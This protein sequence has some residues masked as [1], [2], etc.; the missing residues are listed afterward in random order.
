[1]AAK[2]VA[3]K[4]REELPAGF[5]PARMRL[6]GFFERE[7]GNS[8]QGILRGA[9]KVNGKFGVKNVF[10]I[11]VTHGETQVGEGEMV[12]PGGVVGLDQ[13]GYTS[14]LADVES[15]TPVFV[16]YDGLETPG[17]DASK[18]NP[19]LFTVGVAD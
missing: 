3:K 18:N 14:A 10:R 6:D 16:R 17:Q 9:F 12:G 19:H 1:M 2:K 13:T 11:E 7:I 4:T 15:G 5:K 8:V